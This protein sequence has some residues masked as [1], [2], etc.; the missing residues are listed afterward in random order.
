[1][2]LHKI[3]LPLIFVS[4]ATGATA[5]ELPQD[6]VATRPTTA[7]RITSAAG[8]VAINAGVTEILKHTVSR[9][10]PNGDDNGSFPSRHTSWAFTA[11][12]I[13]ANELYTVSPWYALGSQAAASAIAL[14]RVT[15]GHHYAS[16]VVAGAAVGIASTQLSYWL[17]S[18]I[19]RTPTAFDR[20]MADNDFRPSLAMTSEAVFNLRSDVC[21]GVAVALRGQLPL[22]ERW[23]L[24]ATLRGGSTPVKDSDGKASALNSFGATV[25]GVGHFQLPVKSLAIESSVQAGAVRWLPSHSWVRADYGFHADIDTSLDWRLTPRFSFRTTLGY[26]LTTIP[27]PESSITLSISSVAVF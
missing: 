7:S 2:K 9:R 19:F 8:A 27:T 1:M 26:R 21:M 15:S 3:L 24:V 25:G 12:G 16:D 11:S 13:I 18:K 10:R 14:Q 23:G 6:S 17:C 22:S 5:G 20:P 4:M